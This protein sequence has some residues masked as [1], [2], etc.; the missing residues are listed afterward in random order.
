[1]ARGVARARVAA[2]AIAR[3][4]PVGPGPGVRSG[5]APATRHG[6]VVAPSSAGT[7][8]G[9]APARDAVTLEGRQPER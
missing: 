4:R 5:R 7:V 8:G 3:M 2:P 6:N 9:H 1:M